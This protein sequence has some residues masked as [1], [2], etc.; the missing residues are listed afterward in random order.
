MKGKRKVPDLASS[1][2]VLGTG[3]PALILRARSSDSALSRV[4]CGTHLG[5][6]EAH[7]PVTW[8]PLLPLARWWARRAS[9]LW[10]KHST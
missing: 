10:C 7:A 4:I 1:V 8:L 6:S 9:F 5:S 2:S 3:S